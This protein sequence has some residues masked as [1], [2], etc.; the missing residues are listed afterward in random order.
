MFVLLLLGCILA[1]PSCKKEEPSFNYP[2]ETLY[3][4][5]EG[6][7]VKISNDWINIENH[8]F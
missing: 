6:T 3:G 7:D 2:L 5:W 8:F 1:I 4:K